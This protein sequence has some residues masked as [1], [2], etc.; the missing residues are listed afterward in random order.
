[1]IKFIFI[2]AV[3]MPSGEITVDSSIMDE[4]P[5]KILFTAQMEDKRIHGDIRS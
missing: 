4:C 2:L 5:E 3:I 1:M